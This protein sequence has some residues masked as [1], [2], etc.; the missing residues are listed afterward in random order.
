MLLYYHRM[1]QLDNI[2]QDMLRILEEKISA[3]DRS[4][5]NDCHGYREELHVLRQMY[6]V[7][8]L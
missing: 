2:R 8:L 1:D 3:M 6:E 7:P 4:F 5:E